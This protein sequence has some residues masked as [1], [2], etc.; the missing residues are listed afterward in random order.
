MG[1]GVQ[2]GWDGCLI[3]QACACQIYQAFRHGGRIGLLKSLPWLGYEHYI[4]RATSDSKAAGTLSVDQ[5]DLHLLGIYE[6]V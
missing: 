1:L 4:H 3:S 5:H 6:L 2:T